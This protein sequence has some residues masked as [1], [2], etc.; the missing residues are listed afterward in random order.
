MG[1]N[2]IPENLRTPLFYAEVTVNGNGFP[3][4]GG[5]DGGQISCAGATD[6][7]LFSG[8]DGL[9]NLVLDGVMVGESLD[10]ADLNYLIN[11]DTNLNDK[12]T[13]ETDGFFDIWN[14]DS[15]PHR[16]TLIPMGDNVYIVD[17]EYSTPC[18]QE[19]PDGSLAFCLAPVVACDPV[20]YFNEGQ[21]LP[22]GQYDFEYQVNGDARTHSHTAEEVISLGTLISTLFALA[23]ISP[24]VTVNSGGGVGHFQLIYGLGFGINAADGEGDPQTIV[25]TSLKQD[26]TEILPDLFGESSLTIH[27]C[28][29][30]N[31][32]GI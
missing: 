14:I 26:D 3:T 10:T 19:N 32:D 23:D 18:F 22:A 7:M 28:G 20:G 24:V 2:N 6:R 1:F 16:L 31:F 29:Q 27:A 30:Q 21:D 17:S 5:G 15:I 13:S 8:F 12:L 4:S 25:I 11:T 9:W